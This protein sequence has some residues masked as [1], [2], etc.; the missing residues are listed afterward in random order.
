ME[1]KSLFN[2][3]DNNEIIERI[4]NL[5]PDSKSEWGKMNVSQVLAHSQAPLRVA[6]G[7][8]KL[9]RGL[10]GILFGKMAKKKLLAETFKKNMPT[11]KAFIVVDDRNFEEEKNKLIK[12]VR[13]FAEDGPGGITKETHPFFGE[14]TSEEWDALQWKHLDHHLRQFGV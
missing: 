10:L 13:R 2:P 8:V 5:K 1:M 9:K 3:N 14:L 12:L 4:N 7:E 11:D 6:F